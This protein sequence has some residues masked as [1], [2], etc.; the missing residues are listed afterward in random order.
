VRIRLRVAGRALAIGTLLMA[1]AVYSQNPDTIA[2]EES[3][4]RAKK[5]LAQAVEAR[6]GQTYLGMT[7]RQCDGR[8]ALIGHNGELNGYVGFKDTWQYPDTD[9]TDY[10]AHGRHTVLG[11]I[12]GVQDLE[13]THGGH[14]ITLYSGDHGWVMERGGVSELPE[15]SISDFQETVRQNLENMLRVQPKQQGINL[16]WGGLDTVDLRT[17]DWIEIQNP[18]ESDRTT[19]LAI[20]HSSHLPVRSI[21]VTQD[22]ELNQSREDVT[23]YSNYQPKS[24]VLMPMQITRERDGRRIS[25]VFYDECRLNMG[26]PGDYFTRAGLE[27]AF[28]ESGGKVKATKDEK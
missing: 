25:Q 3:A 11:F 4:A 2:P 7:S 15:G 27:K 13:I 8:R 19:R 14:V 17:V 26:L 23:I 20:D 1:Q 22:R 16:R 5:A 10:I 6:G 28:K 18:D 24:G 21:V 9:R 12:I